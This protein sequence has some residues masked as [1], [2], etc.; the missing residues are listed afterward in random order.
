MHGI[1]P[2]PGPRYVFLGNPIA[3]A[4]LSR[5]YIW[6][7]PIVFI[8]VCT[9]SLALAAG[10]VKLTF[11]SLGQRN[12]QRNAVHHCTILDCSEDRN[13]KSLIKS[14]KNFQLP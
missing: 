5:P 2:K 10:T 8:G 13:T 6:W 7:R 9:S 3:G 14:M 4:L 12:D 1:N 11:I